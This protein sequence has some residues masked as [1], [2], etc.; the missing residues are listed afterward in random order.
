MRIGRHDPAVSS[1]VTKELHDLIALLK[2]LRYARHS[3][4]FC[5][6]NLRNRLLNPLPVSRMAI[7]GRRCGIIRS[8]TAILKNVH[9]CE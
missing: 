9:V 8:L 4:T 1:R 5:E 6:H 2:A 3:P 7:R